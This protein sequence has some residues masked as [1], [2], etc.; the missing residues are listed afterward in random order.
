MGYEFEH[1]SVMGYEFEH[2]PV[3]RVLSREWDMNNHHFP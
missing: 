2:L 1:V 3:N